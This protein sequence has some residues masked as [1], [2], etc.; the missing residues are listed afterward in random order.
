M[1]NQDT[2]IW[3]NYKTK[4]VVECRYHYDCDVI[5]EKIKS[6]GKLNLFRNGWCRL[7]VYFQ[8]SKRI[9]IV[10][11]YNKKSL[12]HG[13]NKLLATFKIDTIITETHELNNYDMRIFKNPLSKGNED[14]I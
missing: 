13:L 5:S 3:Y 1:S 10:E 12:K 11:G 7:G 4:E 14:G 9:G 6:E 2:R 8:N